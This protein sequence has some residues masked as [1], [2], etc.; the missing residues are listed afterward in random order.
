MQEMYQKQLKEM[1]KQLE[2]EKGVSLEEERRNTATVVEEL[3]Q[4]KK[5]QYRALSV[6]G[7]CELVGVS[8]AT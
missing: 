1:Q 6:I 7:S 8:S 5:V 2:H 3:E 4:V